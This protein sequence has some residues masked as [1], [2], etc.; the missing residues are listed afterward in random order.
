[1]SPLS[2]R[3]ALAAGAGAL[4]ALAGCAG[5]PGRSGGARSLTTRP[6]GEWGHRA[7]DARNT[8][9]A[10]VTVPSRVAP[11]WDRGE[12]HTAAP[13]VSGGSVFSV[14]DGVTS[15]EGRTG[16]L[17]WET[18]LGG[19]VQ[20][21]PALVDDHLILA[22][23]DPT[24]PRIVALARDDGSEVWSTSLPA[25]V[26]GAVTATA[27]PPL[28]TVPL[29]S[30]GLRAFDSRT[31]DRLWQETTIGARQATVADG[32]V[33]VAGYRRDHDTGVLRAVAAT[34]GSR[35][36][37]TGLDH[38]DAPPV[39]ANGDLVVADGGTLAVHDTADGARKRDLGTFGDWI[40]PPP[41][42]ADH[43]MYVPSTD[44]GLVAISVDDGSIDWRTDVR[45]TVGT[46]VTVGRDAIVAAATTL[47]G[48][49]LPG[50]VALERSDGS[51]RWTHTIDGFDAA[52][53][54]APILAD[55]AVFYASNESV[56]VV[57]L[58]DLG[59]SETDGG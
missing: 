20:H 39:F 30:G 55:G 4:A 6:T 57:A 46:G 1:M 5:W 35:V 34:D 12:A 45:V 42:V 29:G 47:P 11:A 52:A 54:T 51:P 9:T 32:T 7:H 3:R 8:A 15:L 48:D 23:D 50:I 16:E 33:Y 18:D 24:N 26:G 40:D 10:A 53:S 17:R 49:S 25:P 14:G 59:R 58:G 38:P 44:G 13:L 2:R 19:S 27:D 43:T 41:A 28:V 56:G 37:E 22:T 21:A 31:G 36:W